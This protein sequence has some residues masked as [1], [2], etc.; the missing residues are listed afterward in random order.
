MSYTS[1]ADHWQYEDTLLSHPGVIEELFGDDPDWSEIYDFWRE[2]QHGDYTHFHGRTLIRSR[3]KACNGICIYCSRPAAEW[4][5][6]H[7]TDFRNPDN[8]DSLCSSCHR[9]YDRGRSQRVPE[10]I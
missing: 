3:G 8:Y 2:E 4:A 1:G 5:W 6:R 10:R 7:G 9:Y